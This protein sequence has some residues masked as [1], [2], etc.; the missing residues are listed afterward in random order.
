MSTDPPLQQFHP[1]ANCLQA[2]Y[3]IA[4]PREA[5][6]GLPGHLLLFF[7]ICTPPRSPSVPCSSLGCRC[8][9]AWTRKP[10]PAP[11]EVGRSSL[12]SG[13]PFRY[14]PSSELD[15]NLVIARISFYAVA[16][17]DPWSE[18]PPLSCSV[19]RDQG[20]PRLD[21]SPRHR[22]ASTFRADPPAVL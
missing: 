11:C 6:T 1:T 20:Q 7:A 10:R 21:V 3:Y 19:D 9:T 13:P 22:F 8:V 15:S 12:V 5:N 18:I 14:T 17:S 2:T 4:V 16:Q